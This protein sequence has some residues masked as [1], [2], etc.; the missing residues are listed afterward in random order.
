[1]TYCS[2]LNTTISFS[3]FVHGYLMLKLKLLCSAG[4]HHWT[5]KLFRIL[6]SIFNQQVLC[7]TTNNSFYRLTWLCLHKAK[8]VN[9]FNSCLTSSHWLIF[10]SFLIF[11]LLRIYLTVLSVLGMLSRQCGCKLTVFLNACWVYI[12]I[13]VYKVMLGKMPMFWISTYVYFSRNTIMWI[14]KDGIL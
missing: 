2:Q 11:P 13:N 12:G 4:S 6:A 3:L 10:L 7:W 5:L 9:M 1:M 14:G 8:V